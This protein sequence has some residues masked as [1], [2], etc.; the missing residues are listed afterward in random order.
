M[1]LKNTDK[2]RVTVTNRQTA[3][4]YSDTVTETGTGKYRESGDVCYL[5]YDTGAAKVYIKAA[6]GTVTVKRMGESGSVMEY[7]PQRRTY[8][9]YK[10]PY[11]AI[12]MSVYTE[13]L[14]IDAG[15][16]RISISYSL[17]TGEDEM[18]NDIEIKWEVITR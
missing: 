17:D 15:N 6:R 3:D 13:A 2:Y 12:A 9:E 4:G 7:I 18:R 16:G 10:T 5:T 14:E 1:T 11:G 8:F